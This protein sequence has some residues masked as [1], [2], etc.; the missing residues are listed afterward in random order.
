M[1]FLCESR[2][3]GG[4]KLEVSKSLNNL[5]LGWLKLGTK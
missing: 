5:R 2:W 1:G 4:D 3:L